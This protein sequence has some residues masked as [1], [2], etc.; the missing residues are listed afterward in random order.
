MLFHNMSSSETPDLRL[1]GLSTSSKTLAFNLVKSFGVPF[2]LTLRFWLILV[3]CAFSRIGYGSLTLR[4]V[5]LLALLSGLTG[6]A[7]RNRG[8]L[9]PASDGLV[10]RPAAG[11]HYSANWATCAGRTFTC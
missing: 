3:R 6:L 5:V 9:H 4:P 7:S 8:R 1:L 11:Y 10:T 2:V